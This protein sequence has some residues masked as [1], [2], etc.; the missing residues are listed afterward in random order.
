MYEIG[1]FHVGR[2]YGTEYVGELL[3]ALFRHKMVDD[4]RA[5]HNLVVTENL[6]TRGSQVLVRSRY[7]ERVLRAALWRLGD[8]MFEHDL[9][10]GLVLPDTTAAV[11]GG[12]GLL[13]QPGLF[14]PEEWLQPAMARRGA[15][16][17]DAPHPLV[18]LAAGELVVPEPEVPHDP[19][20][21]EGLDGPAPDA[22]ELESVDP[23][24]LSA[25]RVGR[26]ETG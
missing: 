15:A 12:K 10:S 24:S 20:V 25:H 11:V 1:E 14:A 18:D 21:L 6:L 3:D 7:T 22:D 17:V 23:R 5:G 8:L 19:A 2:R 13:L 4:P 16:L 9:D 26:H